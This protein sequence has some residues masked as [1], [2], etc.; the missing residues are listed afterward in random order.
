MLETI[1]TKATVMAARSLVHPT[2]DTIPIR[3]LNPCGEAVTLYQ[4]TKI[5]TIEEVQDPCGSHFNSIQQNQYI[6]SRLTSCF[7]EHSV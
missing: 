1:D 3:L 2:S 4:G 7:V 5:A 6:I